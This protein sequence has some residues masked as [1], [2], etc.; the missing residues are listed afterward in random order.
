VTVWTLGAAAISGRAKK[1]A[2][3][4]RR[5]NFARRRWSA[6][7]DRRGVKLNIGLAG[8]ESVAVMLLDALCSLRDKFGNSLNT[9]G[10]EEMGGRRKKVQYDPKDVQRY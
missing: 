3:S 10:V 5:K 2:A 9:F 7:R 4:A 1:N 8:E 6:G